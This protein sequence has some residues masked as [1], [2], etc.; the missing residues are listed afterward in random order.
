MADKCHLKHPKKKQVVKDLLKKS[1]SH[2]LYEFS[3]LKQEVVVLKHKK[4]VIISLVVVGVIAISVIGVRHAISPEVQA[5]IAAE[6]G[7]H[8]AIHEFKQDYNNYHFNSEQDVTNAYLGEPIGEYKLNVD[9]YNFSKPVDQQLNGP[10]GYLFPVMVKGEP[11]SQIAVVLT[12]NHKWD[13]VDFGG[14]MCSTAKSV[15]KKYNLSNITIMNT[16]NG[17]FI[18]GYDKS[19]KFKIIGETFDNRYKEYSISAFNGIIKSEQKILQ[20]F[21]EKCKITKHVKLGERNIKLAFKT[22]TQE[23][24][25]NR[26]VKYFKSIF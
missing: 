25:I 23:P 3:K 19:D 5:K 15:E 16:I 6:K 17:H 7:F 18:V 1:C 12:R 22:P 2:L 4:V 9:N 8:D 20:R 14:D 21:R 24:A 10:G 11:R 13:S 26:L